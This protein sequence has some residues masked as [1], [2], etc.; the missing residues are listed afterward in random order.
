M[1]PAT[2]PAD[3]SKPASCYGGFG[4]HH[5]LPALV[6]RTHAG[7]LP[8]NAEISASCRCSRIGFPPLSGTSS[9]RFVIRWHVRS[10][11]R[12]GAGRPRRPVAMSPSLLPE[13]AASGEGS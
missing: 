9:K 10:R 13:M 6:P 8:R 12:G 3:I 11:L 7:R 4:G 1:L 5:S 2:T